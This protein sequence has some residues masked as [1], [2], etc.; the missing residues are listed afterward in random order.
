M[1]S[2][3]GEVLENATLHATTLTSKGPLSTEWCY[4]NM[5]CEALVY[6]MGQKFQHY[7]FV[8]EVGLITEHKLLVA[9]LSKDVVTL[10]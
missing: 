10:S 4:S 2:G 6:Y 1:N 5:E 9:I 7:C 3:Y 8:R